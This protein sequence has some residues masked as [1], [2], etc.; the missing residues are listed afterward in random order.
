MAKKLA[1]MYL[2]WCQISF[3]FC[4]DSFHIWSVTTNDL[5]WPH[6]QLEMLFVL[7]CVPSAAETEGWSLPP[8][9]RHK[10]GDTIQ[11]FLMT[12]APFLLW[13]AFGNWQRGPHC[14]KTLMTFS[15]FHCR[16]TKVW[17]MNFSVE[18]ESCVWDAA[19][20]QQHE[21]IPTQAMKQKKGNPLFNRICMLFLWSRSV[22]MRGLWT[23]S[24]C[25][26]RTPSL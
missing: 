14:V 19:R 4:R 26:I 15:N 8:H 13:V 24:E 11:P 7:L 10:R 16:L 12:K 21:N 9:Q 17:L 2:F 6:P 22:Q 25:G 1:S 20:K 3:A 5:S 18:R 23:F